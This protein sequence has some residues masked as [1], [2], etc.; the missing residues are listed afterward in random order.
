MTAA[1]NITFFKPLPPYSSPSFNG[2]TFFHHNVTG[3]TFFH[4]NV[5]SSTLHGAFFAF[6][7]TL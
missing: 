7:Q 1:N 3:T 4:H 5:I 2:T 6:L